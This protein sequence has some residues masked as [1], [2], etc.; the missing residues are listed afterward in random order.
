LAEFVATIIVCGILP[1][2]F[3]LA[4]KT[5]KPTRFIDHRFLVQYY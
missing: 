5:T 4:K 3:Q 2:D 1:I